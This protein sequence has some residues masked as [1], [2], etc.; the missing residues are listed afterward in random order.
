MYMRQSGWHAPQSLESKGD[1][2]TQDDLS[3]NSLDGVIQLRS[4]VS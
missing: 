1:A 2:E 4:F 3:N